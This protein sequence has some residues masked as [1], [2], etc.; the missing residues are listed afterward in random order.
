LQASGITY[1]TFGKPLVTLSF[2][3]CI[4]ESKAY[5]KGNVRINVNTEARSPN[6]F[7]GGKAISIK[8][9]E[10]VSVALVIQHAKRMRRVILPSVACLA[11]RYFSTLSHKRHDFRK[12]KIIEHKMCVLIF[13]TTF[14]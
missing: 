14:V 1:K 3:P 11:A 5:T 7:C 9:Y 2:H 8:Y 10:C 12:K 13:S 4:Q 6:R